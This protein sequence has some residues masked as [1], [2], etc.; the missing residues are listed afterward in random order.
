MISE[1]LKPLQ[2]YYEK[3]KRKINNSI[4]FLSKEFHEKK[5]LNNDDP[6]HPHFKKNF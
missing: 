3:F 2:K 5:V 4:V 1:A 6:I